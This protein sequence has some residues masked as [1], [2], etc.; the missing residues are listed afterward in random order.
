MSLVIWIT[1]LSGAGKSTIAAEVH[2]LM[3]ERGLPAVHLD[4]DQVREVVGDAACGHDPESRLVNAYR[5][6]RLAAMLAAQD[7]PL[8]VSTVSLFHEV[9]AWNRANLSGYF[10]VYVKVRLDTVHR[11]DPKGIYVRASNGEE[12]NVWG[13]HLACEEPENPHLVVE[14]DT[15]LADVAPLAAAVLDAALAGSAEHGYRG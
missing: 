7:L 8:V 11:R 9:H 6:C 1:G 3:R 5:I 13:L 10:E 2:R 4:G 14:N 12:A 15:D